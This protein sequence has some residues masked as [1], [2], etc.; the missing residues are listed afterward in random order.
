[1]QTISRGCALAAL[2]ALV[3]ASRRVISTPA[4]LDPACIIGGFRLRTFIYHQ[5]P[6]YNRHT[7]ESIQAIHN[8]L[9]NAS[10]EATDILRIGAK[11]TT[12]QDPSS[13][14]A[15][16]FCPIKFHTLFCGVNNQPPREPWWYWTCGT[17][18]TRA[19]MTAGSDLILR[20][21]SPRYYCQPR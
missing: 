12:A 6:T 20:P 8:S 16:T 19:L 3:K 9:M 11:Q 17:G 2:P 4:V 1:M 10:M 13:A 5:H 14:P 7:P 15:Q 18:R 21:Q